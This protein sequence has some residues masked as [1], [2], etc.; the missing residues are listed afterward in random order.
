MTKSREDSLARMISQMQKAFARETELPQPVRKQKSTTGE[1][2]FLQLKITLKD[3]SPPIWRRFIVPNDMTLDLLHTCLQIIMGWDNYHLYEFIIGG[4]RGGR[5][6]SAAPDF[7]DDWDDFGTEDATRYDLSFLT[8][9]GMKFTYI[10]DMGDS[11]DHE[12]VAENVNYEHP[13][14]EPPVVV[15]TGKRN[16]PPEDCGGSWGYANLLEALADK[17]HPEHRDMKEWIGEYDSEEF[18]LEEINA[19]LASRIGVPELRK[20]TS[21]KT[22]K[23][24]NKKK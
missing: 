18:D 22:T 20:K 17:K 21:K 3:I 16:C 14:D 2:R 4:R 5:H 24:T 15:L 1:R 6:Y 13:G 23:K 11:W 19:E 10:Y 9:K 8:R 12:I 7:V